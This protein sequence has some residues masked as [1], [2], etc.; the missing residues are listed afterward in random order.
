M[1]DKIGMKSEWAID[2]FYDPDGKITNFLKN[3]GS[4]D[5]AIE[6]NRDHYLG[7]EFIHNNVGLQEGIRE[8]IDIIIGAGGTTLFGSAQAYLGV[9]TSTTGEGSTQTGLICPSPVY[10]AM[11]STYPQRSLDTAEWRATFGDGV[12]QF[13]WQE[14]TVAN[15]NSNAAKNLNRKVADKGTKTAGESWTLSL[16]I[17]FA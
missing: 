13:S 3:G 9:G 12:A 11:D 17:T 7:K 5:E 4:M 15:G 10:V 8:V 6:M 1:E 2:K 14:F 16:K